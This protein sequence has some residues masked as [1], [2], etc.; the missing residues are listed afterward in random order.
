MTAR[1][2]RVTRIAATLIGLVA[3]AL[4]AGSSAIAKP[5]AHAKSGAHGKVGHAKAGHKK[6]GHKKPVHA[7]PG[8]PAPSG[9][10]LPTVVLVNGAWDRSAS[11]D[12]V[13]QRLR[14]AGYPV[15]LAEDP[16]RRLASDA[17]SVADVLHAIAGPIV[18]VGHS[19]GG[20][21][22]TNAARGNPNVKALV[23][24]AGFAPDAGES[25]FTLDIHDLGSQ[26]PLAL[27]PVPITLPGGGL[28]VDLYLNKSLY[29]Q[30]FALDVPAA[31][32]KAM[33]A[34][35]HPVTL[36][37]L[38]DRSG[39]P[40]WKTIPSW[41]M[42]ARNDHAIPP[43]TE[44]FMAARAGAHT[45]EVSSSHAALVSH[46]VEVSNLIVAAAGG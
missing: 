43:A 20:A 11:W 15:V 45:V 36:A 2:R 14:D 18:L 17:A 12:P 6:P 1:S 5:T 38:T 40:A 26:V 29:R 7:K 28:G 4:P 24:I 44:R 42:V 30:V 39:V 37:A 10:A 23:Y 13:A 22:I 19:Y 27:V 3:F 33:A 46:P 25:V 35:Q 16:L 9:A 32:A 31:T 34:A 8:A 21:V 41:Y